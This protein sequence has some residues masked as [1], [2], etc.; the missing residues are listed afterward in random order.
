MLLEGA[1]LRGRSFDPVEGRV[2]EDGT[3]SAVEEDSTRSSDIILP[4]FV[5]AHTHTGDSVSSKIVRRR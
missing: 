3:I 5:N 2:V 1:L 4:A